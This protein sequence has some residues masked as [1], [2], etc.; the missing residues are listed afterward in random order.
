MVAW[1]DIEIYAVAL[2]G[3]QASSSYGEPSLKIGKAL[4]TRLRI[5]DNSA[6]LKSVDCDERDDLMS[7]RPDIFFLE[8]NYV[9][10][11]IVLARLD[12]ADLD[13]VAPYIH[14]T[15]MRLAGKRPGE[16]GTRRPHPS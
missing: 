13:D 12:S 9:G 15:W 4:L 16:S 8:D 7:S 11:D 6:V 14:R 2:G 1:S 5:S 3:V 10:H